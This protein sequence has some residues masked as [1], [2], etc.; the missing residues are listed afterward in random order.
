M[1]MAEVTQLL[2]PCDS[3]AGVTTTLV[4]STVDQEIFAVKNILLVV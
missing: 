4:F 2:V 3:S 1:L